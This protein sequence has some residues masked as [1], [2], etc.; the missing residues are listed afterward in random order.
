MEPFGT[1]F[2]RGYMEE[3][4]S[5]H[6]RIPKRTMDKLRPIAEKKGDTPA[7]IIKHIVCEQLN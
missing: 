1:I 6:I 5:V 2:L 3:M 4:E 7:N